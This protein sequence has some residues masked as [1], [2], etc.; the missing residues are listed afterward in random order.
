MK[1]EIEIREKVKLLEEEALNHYLYQKDR[2]KLS[3]GSFKKL[4]V[5]KIELLKWV[6][7][8]LEDTILKPKKKKFFEKFF[9]EKDISLEKGVT[10]D[11][12]NQKV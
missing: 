12:H 5:T 11:K 8:E 7:G 10:I 9:N 6:L 2:R 1:T 4:I 3:A